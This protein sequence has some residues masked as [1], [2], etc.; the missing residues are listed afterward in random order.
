MPRRVEVFLYIDVRDSRAA[1][2]VAKDAVIAVMMASGGV[3][4]GYRIGETRSVLA[5]DLPGDDEHGEAQMAT[6]T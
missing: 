1:R 5:D 6:A 4:A 3:I 2:R